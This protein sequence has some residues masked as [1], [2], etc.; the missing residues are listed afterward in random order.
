MP[1]HNGRGALLLRWWRGAFKEDGLDMANTATG[2][3]CTVRTT[4][5]GTTVV[6]WQVTHLL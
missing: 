5:D 1:T 6:V 2:T 4:A 3:L